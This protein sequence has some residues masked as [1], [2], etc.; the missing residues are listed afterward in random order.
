MMYLCLSIC[1]NTTFHLLYDIGVIPSISNGLFRGVR[2]MCCC[3]L[4]EEVSA[5]CVACDAV[6][7]VFVYVLLVI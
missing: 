1:S 3:F 7:S 5:L 6:Q 4:L 2:G